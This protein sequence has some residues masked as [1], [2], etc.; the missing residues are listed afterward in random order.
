MIDAA[1][2]STV[3]TALTAI[4]WLSF[5]AACALAIQL[6]IVLASERWMVPLYL[7]AF[8]KRGWIA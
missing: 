3:L 1:V 8:T 7:W 6:P 2:L 4:T 5:A